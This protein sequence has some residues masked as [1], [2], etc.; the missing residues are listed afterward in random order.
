V[1]GD[2]AELLAT[3]SEPI[4]TLADL[5]RV[6]EIDTTEWEIVSWKANKWESA[7]KDAHTQKLVTRPMF[8]VTA[9]MK[10]K[11]VVM[12]A[13]REIEAMIAE[14]KRRIGPQRPV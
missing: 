6:C 11:V 8:Q 7:A 1:D 9:T 3:T 2:R 13:R 4:K 12:A 10:R 5:I 14:A